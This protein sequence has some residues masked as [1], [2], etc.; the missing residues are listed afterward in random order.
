VKQDARDVKRTFG[1]VPL[2]S[3]RRLAESGSISARGGVSM[4]QEATDV[5]RIETALRWLWNELDDIREAR[6]ATQAK[7]VGWL[8]RRA[9]RG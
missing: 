2:D 3:L 6:E 7:P 1:Q 8:R 4:T 5:E 9:R